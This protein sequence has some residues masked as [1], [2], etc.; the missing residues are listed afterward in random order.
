MISAD[1]RW[2]IAYIGELY[3]TAELR[4]Q[5][6]GVNWRGY[7]DTVVLVE[8]IARW[9]LEETLRRAT[10]MLA[11]AAWD[12]E[13]QELWLERDRFGEKPL[14]YGRVGEAW[15]V[16]SELTAFHGLRGFSPSINREAVAALLQFGSI[17]APLCIYSGIHKLPVGHVLRL[18]A[19]DSTAS[20][21]AYWDPAEVATG[22]VR[23]ATDAHFTDELAELLQATVGAR[24][25][26]D[27]PL[28]AFLSGGVDS[29]LVVA[30]MQQQASEAV[31][32][33]T[34]GFE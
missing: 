16:A 8:G 5:L 22:A 19:D 9:G 34:I 32:T 27:V 11:I 21:Q 15:V 23:R 10:A 25:V 1:G 30:L 24:M 26:A 2:V 17:P 3:S 28:G 13:R 6:P 4:A 18:R 20:P 33:F 14:Y 29:S 7:S 12:S 31:Q